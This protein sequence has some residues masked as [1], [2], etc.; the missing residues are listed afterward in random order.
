LSN[1]ALFEERQVRRL[2]HNDEWWFVLVDIV[3]ALTDSANSSDYLKKLRRRD[4]TLAD[5][6]KGGGQ[7]VPPFPSPSKPREVFNSFSAGTSQESWL[8]RKQES[9]SHWRG[10]RQTRSTRTRKNHRQESSFE[11]ELPSAVK[12][13]KKPRLV[14][15]G[16]PQAPYL[17]PCTAGWLAAGGAGGIFE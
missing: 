1:M 7:F 13:K 6:F 10:N 3:S 8:T 12:D 5:A 9:R 17:M 14:E 4:P 15:T 11:G 16:V 2:F